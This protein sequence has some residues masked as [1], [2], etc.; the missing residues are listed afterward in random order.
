MLV[1]VIGKTNIGKSTLFKALTLADVEISNR[2]FVTIKPNHGTGYIKIKCVDSDFKIKCDPKHGYCE[3]GFRFVPVELLDVAGLVPGAH[4][5][6][7]L[8]NQFLDD[9]R[10]ADAF[11]H[12]IDISGSTNDQGET[13]PPGSYDPANDIKFFEHELD[14]WY[15]SIF[16]KIWKKFT[17]QT[18]Q[19]KEDM[20]KAI[21]KQFSGLKVDEDD[22][23][24][25]LK[26]LN[27]QSKKLIGWSEKELKNFAIELRKSTKQMII[28]A[29]KIDVKGAYENFERIKKEFSQYTIIPCSAE[30][31]LALREASRTKLIDYVPGE[32]GFRILQEDKLTEKQKRALEFIKNNVL[33]KYNTTGVQDV[34]NKA[35]F[36]LLNYIAVYPVENESRLTDSRNNVLPDVIL[37]LKGS[38]PIDLAYKIHTDIGNKF[39]CAIDIRTKKRLGKDYILKNKDII[40]INTS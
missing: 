11:I 8:G 5:G 36:E 2:P 21:V 40:K 1:G 14:M 12:V 4:E 16:Q 9:L 6:K 37:V 28:A 38:K 15:Y 19:E 17:Y 24:R 39:N 29:N 32:K 10:Q 13:V 7:G 22:V 33:E 25:A 30:C 20:V 18:N 23:K 31:E 35:V 26:K 3:H 34:L 27:L